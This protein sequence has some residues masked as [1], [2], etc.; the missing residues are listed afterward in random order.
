MG[1]QGTLPPHIGNLSF[2]LSLDLS[3][4]LLGGD[5]P[6]ELSKLRR[7]KTINLSTNRFGG[8]IP[9]SLGGLSGLRELDL[10]HNR[11]SGAIP[12]TIFNI[13]SLE[14]L[15]L[16]HNG[17]SGSLPDDMC[18]KFALTAGPIPSSLEG[19]CSNLQFLSLSGNWFTGTIPKSIGNLTALTF[20]SLG[21]TNLTG[22]YY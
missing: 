21:E 8:T 20:L 10:G 9:W 3:D 14:T 22:T 15:I 4:N 11:L 1:L 12:T 2:L 19:H 7:L 5:L 16:A 6:M 17:L 18:I 13:S